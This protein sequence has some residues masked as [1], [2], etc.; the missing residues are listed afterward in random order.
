MWSSYGFEGDRYIYGID[1]LS[2]KVGSKESDK[3]KIFL[4][5]QGTLATCR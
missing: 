5:P 3:V 1:D 2:R 4:N